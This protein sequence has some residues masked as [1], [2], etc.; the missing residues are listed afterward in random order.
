MTDLL[1]VEVEVKPMC[2]LQRKA[3]SDRILQ[4]LLTDVDHE[5]A[6]ASVVRISHPPI[7]V[8]GGNE[9]GPLAHGMTNKWNSMAHGAKANRQTIPAQVVEH[10]VERGRSW[11][12]SRHIDTAMI[13]PSPAAG[14]GWQ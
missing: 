6:V 9:S 11:D 7:D 5:P 8:S 3:D 13:A 14:R 1:P 4:L 2:L 10:I 12:I